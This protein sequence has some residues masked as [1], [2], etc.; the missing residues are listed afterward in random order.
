M[1]DQ[2]REGES[3]HTENTSQRPN[4]IEQGGIPHEKLVESFRGLIKEHQ[5]TYANLRSFGE[6]PHEPE[7]L[8]P[9]TAVRGCARLVRRVAK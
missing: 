4:L 7:A 6:N 9:E 1:S 2:E 8:S 5:D 3:P